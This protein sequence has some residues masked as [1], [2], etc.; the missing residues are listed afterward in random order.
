MGADYT[1]PGVLWLP[2]ADPATANTQ[3]NGGK[4]GTVRFGLRLGGGGGKVIIL[5]A[6]E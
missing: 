2:G 3:G 6:W 5:G 4:G 1:R